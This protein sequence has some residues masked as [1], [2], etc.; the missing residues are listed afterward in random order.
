MTLE[1]PCR[2]NVGAENK[3]S[4]VILIIGNKVWKLLVE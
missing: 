4:G 3:L 2:L 1:V